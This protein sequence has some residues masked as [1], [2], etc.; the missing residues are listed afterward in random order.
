M[1]NKM[2]DETIHNF[3]SAV[4]SNLVN[5]HSSLIEKKNSSKF[6]SMSEW[7][8]GCNFAHTIVRLSMSFS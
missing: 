7:K 4:K 8:C 3:D 2:N 1:N 6:M 5:K